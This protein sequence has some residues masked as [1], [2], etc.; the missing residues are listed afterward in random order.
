M[1]QV[2][3]LVLVTPA[4]A[5]TS[6]DSSV[7]R[8]PLYCRQPA[9]TPSRVWKTRQGEHQEQA[10][11]A[12][13]T[14][15][16][17]GEGAAC[18]PHGRYRYSS[19]ESAVEPE[20]ASESVDGTNDVVDCPSASGPAALAAL[21]AAR[22]ISAA[23]RRGRTTPPARIRL[24]SANLHH[25]SASGR[26]ASLDRIV[27]SNIRPTSSGSETLH[28]NAPVGA[29]LAC[30]RDRAHAA[31][32]LSLAASACTATQDSENLGARHWQGRAALT[33]GCT[34]GILLA[35]RCQ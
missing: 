9:S 6:A 8:R 32:L 7:Y 4:T 25:E 11:T 31:R 5:H 27:Q 33:G 35:R 15:V 21:A 34:R 12:H 30:Q 28:Q 1:V 23:T 3:V 26:N 14:K 16:A 20:P 13:R 17:V 10:P 22:A 2:R 19:L 18:C 24:L 29:E